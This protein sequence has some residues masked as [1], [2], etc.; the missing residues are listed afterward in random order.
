M[1][2]RI[3]QIKGVVSFTLP[4]GRRYETTNLET[5]FIRLKEWDKHLRAKG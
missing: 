1:Y 4:D 3:T 2:I 5:A